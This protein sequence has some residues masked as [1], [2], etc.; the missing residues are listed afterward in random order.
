MWIT[1]LDGFYSVVEHRDRKNHALVRSRVKN[2]LERFKKLVPTAGKIIYLAGADYPYRVIIAK[3]AL[4]KA[5][6]RM[7]YEVKYPNFKSAVTQRLGK[8]RAGVYMRVW[9][10]L[11]TLETVFKKK[12]GE[13]FYDQGSFDD[14]WY[15]RSYGDSILLDGDEQGDFVCSDGD[16]TL[17]GGG[18]QEE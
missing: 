15:R 11:T 4:A 16:A 9:G 14:F 3:D 17:T 6:A 7:A 2:D 5:M 18:E 1:T 10:V 12:G 13:Q 8:I